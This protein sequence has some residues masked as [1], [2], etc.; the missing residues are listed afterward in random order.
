ML[1]QI[2]SAGRSARSGGPSPC[3]FP[4][5]RP[6]LRPRGPSAVRG[7]PLPHRTC[8]LRSIE[9]C[10]TKSSKSA[11]YLKTPKKCP[12]PFKGALCNPCFMVVG[13]CPV[14]PCFVV[15]FIAPKTHQLDVHCNSHGLNANSENKPSCAAT[16]L[17]VITGDLG[18][19]EST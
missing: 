12:D 15:A 13:C 11:H 3:P 6:Q 2:Q 17:L 7:T 1:I 19:K 4:S 8:Q 9:G 5:G 18:T 14:A 10:K 16:L